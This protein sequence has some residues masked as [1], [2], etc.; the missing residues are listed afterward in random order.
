MDAK[1]CQGRK[2]Q[3]HI[4]YVRICKLLCCTQYDNKICSQISI[5]HELKLNFNL[6]LKLKVISSL[7][8][9]LMKSELKWE[10]CGMTIN[11]GTFRRELSHTTYYSQV[12]LF[13]HFLFVFT[14]IRELNTSVFECRNSRPDRNDG[15]VVIGVRR[16][17]KISTCK[18]L[19][20]KNGIC[21]IGMNIRFQKL[22]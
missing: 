4:L 9:R 20:G 10:G 16:L 12:C 11:A 1:W 21:I 2:Q 6:K 19:H 3:H 15:S 7:S 13:C 14:V 22:I 17:R 18:D 8:V 5:D